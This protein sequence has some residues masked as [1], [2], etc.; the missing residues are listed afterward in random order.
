MSIIKHVP[1]A[2]TL[3]GRTNANAVEGAEFIAAMK[4]LPP[5]KARFVKEYLITG[6]GA[7]ACKRAGYKTNHPAQRA[8]LLL[9]N[10][11]IAAAVDAGRLD[12]AR[13]AQ[14]D[15]KKAMEELDSAMEFAR[16]SNNAT[17]LARC[18]ELKSKL[19]GLLIDRTDLRQV[20]NF[21]VVISGIDR[22]AN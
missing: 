19:S 12:I 4:R 9:K 6:E 13:N 20:G 15:L 11:K 5:K 18:I 2:D 17:A 8:H 3:N 7:A 21:S 10:G 16:K 22:P 1:G 14:Y